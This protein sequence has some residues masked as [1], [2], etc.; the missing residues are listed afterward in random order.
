M[1]ENVDDSDYRCTS[2]PGVNFTSIKNTVKSS[3]YFYAFGIYE[4]KS[5]TQN[6]DE[7]EPRGGSF[8]RQMNFVAANTETADYDSW[9]NNNEEK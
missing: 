7:F 6:V 3:V 2:T 9:E 5:C 8:V 4:C 1:L